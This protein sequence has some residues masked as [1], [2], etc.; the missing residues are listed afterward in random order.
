MAKVLYMS[1][2]GL[3][4]PLG[5]SQ[6]LPYLTGLAQKGHSISIL[7]F[8]KP[9]R[10]TKL[11]QEI[12]AQCRAVN[13]QWFP[14]QYHKRPPVLSTVYDVWMLHRK[15]FSLYQ[16]H[17]YDMV[18]CRSYITSLV[19]L[20]MKQRTGIRFLFDMRGFWVE[21]RVEGGLWNLRNPLYKAVHDFFKRKEK[22]FI[23]EADSIVSLTYKAKAY[24]ERTF[25]AGQHKIIVIPCSA[26][27]QFFKPENFSAGD[28]QALREKLGI[29]H[30]DFVLLYLGS[31]GT[32]YCYD[33]MVTF[34]HVLKEKNPKA[35]FLF[36]TPD[37]DRVESHPDF[38][39]VTATRNDVAKYASIAQLAVYF[40]KPTF[41]KSASSATKMA[42]LMAMRIPFITNSDIGDI[43]WLM[44]DTTAGYV[45]RAHDTNEYRK[46]IGLMTDP[47]LS[48]RVSS[49][50]MN[51]LDIR[52]SIDA[53]DAIY[54][55]AISFK[56]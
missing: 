54:N 47:S 31:L 10:F 32:W 40:I 1:Y 52:T 27:L 43:E 36:V 18:H 26:D 20:R 6:I 41:S 39:K 17:K 42:E 5:Q 37:L 23:R 46:A 13:I 50:I 44:Q 53:Y 51:F 45:I 56:Y 33:E 15:A 55:E 25:S 34:Y 3:T 29:R 48:F 4:D 7:S 8:E 22:Q 14:L 35:R 19:G 38:I 9:D 30:D 2:D 24:I 21:E 49:E 12:E 11:R 16:Q 28:K